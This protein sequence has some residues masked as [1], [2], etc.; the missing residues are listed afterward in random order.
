MAY[1]NYYFR[2]GG[3]DAAAER[4]KAGGAQ[5]LMGPM[6]V[7]GGD[8][9]FQGIDPQGAMFAVQGRKDQQH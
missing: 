4:A 9:V 8:W 6:E 1:W 7:P 2:V 3:I 5:I